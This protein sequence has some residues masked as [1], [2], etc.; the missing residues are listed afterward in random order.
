MNNDFRTYR[1][2]QRLTG[3]ADGFVRTNGSSIRVGAQR[4]ANAQSKQPQGAL[5]G[6]K[7]TDGFHGLANQ[8]LH[9]ATSAKLGA[10]RP[11]AQVDTSLPGSPSRS[12]ARRPKRAKR[13]VALR[14]FSVLVFGMI[15]LGGYMVGKGYIAVHSV[16]KGGGSAPALAEEV[17]PTTLNGEGDGRVNIMLLGKGSEGHDGADLTDTI[18]VVSIDPVNKKASILSIPRDLWVEN[19]S[20]GSSKINAVFAN[21]KNAKIGR[22]PTDSQ[23]KEAYTAGVNALETTVEEA[24]GI[25]VHYY[26]VVDFIAFEQAIN[27]VG[28][29]DLNIDPGDASGIVKE[30]LWDELTGKNY[31]LDVKAG[32]NHFDGQRA[33]MYS[34]SR[35]TS[36]RGDFDRSERQ[37]KIMLALKDKVLSAGTY[38]NP[39]KISQLISDFGDHVSSNLSIGEVMRIYELAKSID[40]ATVNSLGLADAP[41][42]FVTTDTVDGQ[43]IVRP[44]AGLSDFSAIKSFVR[45]ALKDSY[46]EKE[47]ANVAVYNGSKTTGLA[48]KRADDLKSYGY[49]VTTVANAPSQAYAQTV[50]VDLTNGAK[51]YTKHYLEDRFKVSAV[52]SMPDQ[53]IETSGA[54]FVI[55]LGQNESAAP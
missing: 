21:A 27:T 53:A 51:K 17:D 26:A 24:M 6:F 7:R 32:Q 16:F 10:E 42:N 29:V 39:V 2:P 9:T 20:G 13:R 47:S 45:N 4:P 28:G 34:R 18:L 14:M 49:T 15:I 12:A 8:T 54:D 48:A 22:N 52:T 40:S 1:T 43:S 35:H 50:I 31:V 33:L 44:I 19:P 30:Q 38:G 37:R 46:L 25:P 23:K 11:L 41:N 5:D 3:S 36:A 55:I